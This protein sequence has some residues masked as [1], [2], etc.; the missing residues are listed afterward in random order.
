MNVEEFLKIPSQNIS[1]QNSYTQFLISRKAASLF[2]RAILCQ[3][4]EPFL[5]SDP[6]VIKPGFA[7]DAGHLLGPLIGKMKQWRDLSARTGQKM[8]K[9][10][11]CSRRCG[12]DTRPRRFRREILSRRLSMTVPSMTTASGLRHLSRAVLKTEGECPMQK[13]DTRNPCPLHPS[14]A[15]ASQS[16]KY[17]Q[18]PSQLTPSSSPSTPEGVF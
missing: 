17:D 8:N 1:L 12:T 11:G 18:R 16:L 15:R 14:L 10:G 2:Q 5:R 3:V 4:L 9:F 13:N 7:S 6:P